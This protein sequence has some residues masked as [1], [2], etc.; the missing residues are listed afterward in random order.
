MG[1]VLE[2]KAKKGPQVG[3]WGL[4]DRTSHEDSACSLVTLQECLP[5]PEQ[6]ALLHGMGPGQDVVTGPMVGT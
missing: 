4:G 5:L 1:H 6:S 2:L 3:R